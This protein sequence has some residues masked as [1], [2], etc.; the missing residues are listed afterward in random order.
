MQLFYEKF[1]CS[2]KHEG[3]QSDWFRIQSAVRQGCVMSGFL[4]FPVID[5]TMQQVTKRKRGI[6]LGRFQTPKD[7]DF[8]DDLALLSAI[9]KQMQHKTDELVKLA[10]KSGLRVSKSK[11]KIM[12]VNYKAVNDLQPITKGDKELEDVNRFLYLGSLIDSEEIATADISSRISKAQSVFNKLRRVWT[13]NQYSRKTEIKI[14]RSNVLSILMYGAE[15]WK[16]NKM[17]G[18]KINGFHNQ[19][20]RRIMKLF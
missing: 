13:S 1:N 15:C 12:Q 20:L 19:C 4:F 10:A 14:Y 6:N 11:T 5:W 2:A 7:L 8:A 9:S 16:I 18:N 3:K 17:D